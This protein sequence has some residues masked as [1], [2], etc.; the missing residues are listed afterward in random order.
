MNNFQAS[1]ILHFDKYCFTDNN[2]FARHFALVLLPS[3]VMGYCNNVL[4]SVITSKKEKY[5]SLQL[6]NN[7]Y[8]CFS[9]DSYVCFRRRDLEDVS[10]LSNGK[11]P[12]DTLNKLDIK[13]AFKILKSVLYGAKD[14]Y[15]TA[16]IV[17]EWKKIK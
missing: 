1:N 12:V 15:M 17:R 9:K 16:T 10:D 13:E 3:S 5:Y 2:T 14:M 11:Q 6:K 7:K 4:C 8:R